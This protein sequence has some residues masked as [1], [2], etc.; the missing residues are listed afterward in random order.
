M[1]FSKF[2]FPI[3]LASTLATSTS[4][5]EWKSCGL[6]SDIFHPLEV[7]MS[8][9]SPKSGEPVNINFKGTL[10][11]PIE[12]GSSALVTVHMNFIKIYQKEVDICGD[13]LDGTGI[14]CPIPPGDLSITKTYMRG[15][16]DFPPMIITTHVKAYT[17][18][19]ADIACLVLMLD[20]PARFDL[21]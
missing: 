9:D 1:K 20:K 13:F 14:S 3:F 21:K 19:E 7:E 5:F 18:D 15:F 4:D 2:A 10:S 6:D 16:P 17:A 8:P 11:K 12:D